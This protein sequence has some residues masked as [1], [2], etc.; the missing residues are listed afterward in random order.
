MTNDNEIKLIDWDNRLY[1][2]GVMNVG[3]DNDTILTNL[4][5]A[6]MKID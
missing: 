3:Y 5:F 4:L 6:L 1:V 2:D